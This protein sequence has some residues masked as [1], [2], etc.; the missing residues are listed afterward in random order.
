MRARGCLGLTWKDWLEL[1]MGLITAI[2][3]VMEFLS[4]R[5]EAE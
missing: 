1:A 2:V 3:A 5:E 4:K